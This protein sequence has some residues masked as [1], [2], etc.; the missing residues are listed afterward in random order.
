MRS[1]GDQVRITAQLIRVDNGFHLWSETFDRKLEN[2]FAVQEEIAAAIAEALVGELGSTVETVPNQT[3]NMAAYDT[4]LRGRAALRSR[5]QEAVALLE[6]ATAA[7]PNF[8]PAWA[9]LAIAY[10]S[11]REDYQKGMD[12]A[13]KALALD[14][15]NVDALNAMGSGLRHQRRW[16]EAEEYFDRALAVD[17][18]SAELLEDYAEFLNLVGRTQEA[19][20][21]TTRGVEIDSRLV[22][23]AFAHMDALAANGRSD[24]AFKVAQ[25]LLE[26]SPPGNHVFVESYLLPVLLDPGQGPVQIGATASTEIPDGAPSWLVEMNGL[27]SSV[28]R[29]VRD[30]RTIEALKSY[31]PLADRFTGEA[32]PY[33]DAA[34]ARAALV[35]AKELD[36]VIEQDIRWARQIDQFPHEFYWTPFF[37][38]L[39]AHPRFGEYL[40]AARLVEYWDATAWPDWCERRAPD[41]VSCR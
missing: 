10:Q 5:N 39:R 29:G 13:R 22:P 21:V 8:A 34:P 41:N 19:L 4:Y 17:P 2:I 36:Y 37:A 33:F 14:A 30:A 31:Y 9:A 26:E 24:E 3:R 35:L 7:D 28:A 16:Q 40:E 12:I 11:V 38:E 32:S 20:A 27:I 15:D 18:N 25:K 6:R 23:L 1:Q